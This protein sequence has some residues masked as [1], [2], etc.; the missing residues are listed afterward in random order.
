MVSW[1]RR[2]PDR[3]IDLF[4]FFVYN[5]INKHASF[6]RWFSFFYIV[7][8]HEYC[9]HGIASSSIIVRINKSLVNGMGLLTYD[10]IQGK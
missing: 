6:I 7:N 10:K 2:F 9:A 4:A 1:G 3:Y 8:G 5:D